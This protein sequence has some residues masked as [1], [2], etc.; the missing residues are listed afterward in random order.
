MSSPYTILG[1]AFH[2]VCYIRLCFIHNFKYLVRKKI[3]ANI[4]LNAVKNA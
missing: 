1:K 4:I 2:S 3:I